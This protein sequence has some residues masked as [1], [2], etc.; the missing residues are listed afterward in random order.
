MSVVPGFP[1]VE[2]CQFLMTSPATNLAFFLPFASSDS[3]SL[4]L[5]PFLLFLSSLSIALLL[6]LLPLFVLES[7]LLVSVSLLSLQFPTKY[8][9]VVCWEF[10]NLR[11][12]EQ[13]GFTEVHR[14]Q[15]IVTGVARADGPSVRVR[16]GR[17][18]GGA[19]GPILLQPRLQKKKEKRH[20]L[21]Q[22][23]NNIGSIL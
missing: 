10:G 21:H 19:T 1:R 22:C 4:F 5:F 7:S 12:R 15:W 6:L 23:Y 8:Y 20:P 3:S 11:S 2:D 16:R 13:N 18:A 14:L 9:T 17:A